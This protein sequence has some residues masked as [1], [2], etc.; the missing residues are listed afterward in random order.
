MKTVIDIPEYNPK[1]GFQFAWADGFT[2]KVSYEYNSV[3]IEANKEGLISLANH[4][5][6]L[7]QDAMPNRHHIH[8]DEYNSLEEGSI[9]LIIEKNTDL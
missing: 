5:L 7:A 2:I 4:C 8:L 6:N 3:I 9:E 1:N